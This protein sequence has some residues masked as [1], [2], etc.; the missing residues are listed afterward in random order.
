MKNE[1]DLA[2]EPKKEPLPCKACGKPTERLMF[3]TGSVQHPGRDM[4]VCPSCGK[5]E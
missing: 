1:K 2:P 5:R 3:R 4:D